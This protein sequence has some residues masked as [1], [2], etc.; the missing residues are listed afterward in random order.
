MEILMAPITA[1]LMGAGA[2]GNAYAEFALRYPD[3]LRI[4][5]V[6][7]PDASRRERFA[8]SHGLADSQCFAT[9]EDLLNAG[10]RADAAINATMD[11]M[12]YRS[13]LEALSLGYEVLLE[14]PMSP[15][16]A[17]NVELIRAAEQQGR[18]LQ[19]CHV[20]R[21]APFF[22]TLR[23]V[24]D[25]GVLG[26]IISM[27]LRE[28][29]SFWHMAHSYVRGN[30]ASTDRAAPMILAKCC[31][32][33]DI[34]VWLLRRDVLWLNSFGALTHFTPENAPRSDVPLRCTDGCPAAETCKYEARRIYGTDASGGIYDV[35][36]PVRTVE[37]RLQALEASPYGRCVYRCDNNVVDHQT[38][39]M[40]FEDDITVTL[41]MN[42]Q[43]FEEG[44]SLRIDGTKA[45]ITGKFS[46][47]YKLNV[48]HH[49]PRRKE[50]VPVVVTEKSGHGGGDLRLVR[51]FVNA[52]QGVD[53]PSLTTARVSLESHLLAFAAE[54]S[55]L[56]HTVIQMNQYRQQAETQSSAHG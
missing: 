17:E 39:N 50:V 29:L 38:V 55:R 9:W 20:L 6:A 27:D 12:H 22:Q 47:P 2:R 49:H 33:L 19:V 34:L 41:I 11:G 8:R 46:E 7:E 56:N 48:Y 18:L 3:A 45:T 24:V 37:A 42:G 23:Q 5:A 51:G 14:K 1:V 25:S 26:Q 36:T 13:T 10:K 54:E 44:R 16:L 31:H 32:D 52:L 15:V 28:N 21:Y 35:L 4:V 30:W 53:D 43:G 40:A